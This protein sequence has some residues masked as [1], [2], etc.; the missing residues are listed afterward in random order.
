MT[1]SKNAIYKRTLKGYYLPLADCGGG[2][3]ESLSKAL[4]KLP[5]ELVNIPKQA[6]IVFISGV[7]TKSTAPRLRDVLS[8]L[9]KPFFTV[10]IGACMAQLNKKF[11]DPQYNY[12]IHDNTKKFF[13]IKQSIEGCPPSA[14][15]IISKL[16]SY[17]KYIDLTPDIAKTLEDKLA[18][19][20]KMSD[21]KLDKG[22]FN[23]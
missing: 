4:E 9:S 6:D 7:I 11:E 3:L 13:S 15:D 1:M 10:K 19:G 17:F 2:C 22:L 21:D 8:G 12:A 5:I 16:E 20:T 14:E 23:P 18:T